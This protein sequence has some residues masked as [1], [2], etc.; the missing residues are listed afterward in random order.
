MRTLSRDPFA[1][2]ELQSRVVT[3]PTSCHWCGG[4]R[5]NKQGFYRLFAYFIAY[6]SIQGKV[7]PIQGAY[8][9]VSCMR[10]YNF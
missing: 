10:S 1:R 9:S 2:E 6:D 4:G 3:T 7:E 8:C 5:T